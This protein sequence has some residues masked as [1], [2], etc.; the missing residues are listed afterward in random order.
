MEDV[1]VMKF[2]GSATVLRD[3][4]RWIEAI[5]RVSVPAILV[6]GGGPFADA[7][8]HNKYK[9]G[10]SE[11]AAHQMAILAMEQFGHALV[12]LGRRMVPANSEDSFA[13]AIAGGSI[14]V[15]M[16]YEMLS[17]HPDIEKSWS[18]TADALS[19][20]L[21]ARLG[22]RQVLL[23][24]QLPVPENSTLDALRGAEI[25]DEAFMRMLAPETEVYIAGPFDLSG[26]GRRFAE[27]IL[28]GRPIA[29]G[30]NYS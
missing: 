12:S 6:P 24:K 8:R 20:W 13:S 14:P 1:L 9:M 17:Q 16:P 26:A 11:E 21:A 25:I 22:C 3:L 29:R 7:V 4:A 5:E 10:Y 19:A 18:V 2:G 27:G 28:P 23:I 15:W 30:P